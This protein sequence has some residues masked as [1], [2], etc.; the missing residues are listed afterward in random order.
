[1]ECLERIPWRLGQDA[2]VSSVVAVGRFLPTSDVHI[3]GAIPLGVPARREHQ[4]IRRHRVG[5]RERVCSDRRASHRIG[6]HS[7]RSSD[8]TDR[9]QPGWPR[10]ANRPCRGRRTHSRTIIVSVRLARDARLWFGWDSSA[11]IMSGKTSF[12][13]CP[14]ISSKALSQNKLR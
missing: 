10:S 6:T 14:I 2:N 5:P 8:S 12:F 1:M 7:S 13:P 3:L 9:G 4:P 11:G